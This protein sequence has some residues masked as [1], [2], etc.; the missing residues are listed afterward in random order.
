MDL[1]TGSGSS[2]TR[3]SRP[4]DTVPIGV[5][6]G[7]ALAVAVLGWIA[8][9]CGTSTVVNWTSLMTREIPG[10]L[11]GIVLAAMALVTALATLVA[12]LASRVLA[13]WRGTRRS[14]L[15]GSALAF[16]LGAVAG[17]LSFLGTIPATHA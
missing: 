4:D 15:L 1:D 14:W 9:F 8:G 17:G 3:P 2:T 6:I 12:L 13:R 11:F 7:A 10:L 5:A 16:A